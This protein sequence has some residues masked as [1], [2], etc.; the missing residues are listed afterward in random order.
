MASQRIDGLKALRL[1]IS[2][3][4]V[5]GSTTSLSQFVATNLS[6]TTP[7]PRACALMQQ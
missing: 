3:V 2:L 1:M 6:D 5:L 4:Y 7:D